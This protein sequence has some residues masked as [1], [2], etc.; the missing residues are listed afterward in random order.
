MMAIMD[1][2]LPRLSAAQAAARL[3]VRQQTLYAYV[4]RGL[5]SRERGAHG[6]TFDALEVEAFASSRRRSAAPATNPTASGSPLMV[7]DT[8]IALIED[9]ELYFRGVPAA[10]LALMYTYE[11]VA[12]WLWERISKR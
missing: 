11:S 4:S 3:G 7:L 8:D 10:D 2:S 5:L 1:A 12:R 9:G 6:S